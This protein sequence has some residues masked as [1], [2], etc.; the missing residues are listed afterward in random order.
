MTINAYAAEK[1]HYKKN[2]FILV[3][4]LAPFHGQ[5]DKALRSISHWLLS[6]LAPIFTRW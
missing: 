2:D 4:S 1:K 3:K 5:V 6:L